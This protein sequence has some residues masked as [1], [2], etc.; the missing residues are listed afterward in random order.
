MVDHAG[1]I[2]ALCLVSAFHPL[3]ESHPAV[4]KSLFSLTHPNLSWFQTL[5]YLKMLPFDTLLNYEVSKITH[6]L[7]MWFYQL[8]LDKTV[9]S[10]YL[11]HIWPNPSSGP[12]HLLFLACMAHSLT[13]FR[14]LL[15]PHLLRAA[16]SDHHV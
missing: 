10:L 7:Q 14:S 9:T 11:E 4:P 2:S 6:I 1:Y 13:S 8:R 16:F 12:L 15:Q 5:Y 3:D